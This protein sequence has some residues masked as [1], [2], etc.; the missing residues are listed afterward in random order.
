MP[1]DA[2]IPSDGS[3][4]SESHVHHS[5]EDPP[6]D[7]GRNPT[8]L[9]APIDVAGKSFIPLIRESMSLVC[10]LDILF[11][12]KGEPGQ[13]IL[14]GGDIENRI[15]TLLD[16][17][18]MPHSADEIGNRRVSRPTYCLLENDSLITGINVKTDRLLNPTMQGDN[19]VQLVI[20]VTVNVI[21]VR[22]YNQKLMGY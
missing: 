13:L 1:N 9:I 7:V 20:G 5:H 17:L 11:L 10:D 4:F 14:P 18:R 16:G 6:S 21:H 22:P 8:N 3:P 2:F 19:A 15:K 12:R